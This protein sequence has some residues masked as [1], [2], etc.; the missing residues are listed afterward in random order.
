MP[1]PSLA[2][3]ALVAALA[4]AAPVASPVTAPEP[5]GGAPGAPA[6]RLTVTVTDSGTADGVYRLRCHPSGGNHPDS[7]AACDALDSALASGSD[8]FAPVPRDQMCTHLYGGPAAARVEGT[9]KGEPVR[10]RFNR[11]NGC[12]IA[13]W[14]NLVPLLPQPGAEEPWSAR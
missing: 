5:A 3:A 12:E 7:R 4:G 2:A 9:W 6:E 8:P 11:A 14:D 10:A 1:Y 13:R